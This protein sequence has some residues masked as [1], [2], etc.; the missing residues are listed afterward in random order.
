MVLLR[1]ICVCFLN[2]LYK[3]LNMLTSSLSSHNRTPCM[4]GTAN[5]C[6]VAN[7]RE[8]VRSHVNF[9]LHTVLS[10]SFVFLCPM[11]VEFCV[12]YTSLKSLRTFC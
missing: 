5:H 6:K 2:L 8:C 1:Y 12:V 10:S 3:M 4:K 11:Y 7:V 9:L